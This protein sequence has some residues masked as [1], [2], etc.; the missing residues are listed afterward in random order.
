MSSTRAE[1]RVLAGLIGSGIQQSLTP[2]LHM[3]EG[4]Q[5]GIDY[6]YELMDLDQV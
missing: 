6:R 4:A 5:Q 1:R 2:A 3:R